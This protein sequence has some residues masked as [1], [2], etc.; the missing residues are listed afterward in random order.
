MSDSSEVAASIR[1]AERKI[2]LAI[3]TLRAEI[4]L[5]WEIDIRIDT[6]SVITIGGEFSTARVVIGARLTMR[7]P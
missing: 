3:S 4:G 2:E 7:G 6:P 5:R 1:R